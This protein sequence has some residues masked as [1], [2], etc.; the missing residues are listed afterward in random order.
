MIKTVA[1]IALITQIVSFKEWW[2][3]SKALDLTSATFF[4]YVGQ[5][6]YV[7]VDFYTKWCRACRYTHPEYDK[8]V[9]F[10]KE[11]RN[12]V[13]VTRIEAGENN[14]I[15]TEYAIAGY[16]TILMFKPFNKEIHSMFGWKIPRTVD[17]FALWVKELAPRVNETGSSRT[18]NPGKSES[19]DETANYD[20]KI[21]EGSI[22]EIQKVRK[23]LLNEISSLKTEL[24]DVKTQYG[25]LM[26]SVKETKNTENKTKQTN[27]INTEKTSSSI[28][29]KN[30]ISLFVAFIIFAVFFIVITKVVNNP[31]KQL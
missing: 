12:D 11:N 20:D 2:E 4:D 14:D 21:D 13:I 9:D 26:K 16:P 6:K 28:S 27:V 8:F 31:K 17:N 3:D 10:I 15:A 29:F 25:V 24:R 30:A 1:I 23:E 18:C 5:E 22:W 19:E 7:I